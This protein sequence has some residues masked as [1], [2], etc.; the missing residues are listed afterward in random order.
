MA[1]KSRSASGTPGTSSSPR[2]MRSRRRAA[3]ADSATS[4]Y[5]PNHAAARLR[6]PA[7]ATPRHSSASTSGASAARRAGVRWRHQADVR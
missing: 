6:L 1:V 5:A 4:R 7:A 3:A 2:Q